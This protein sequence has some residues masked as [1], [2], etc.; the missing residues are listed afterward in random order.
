M[1]F[2]QPFIPLYFED[3]DGELWTALQQIEPERRSEFIKSV[4]RQTLLEQPQLDQ[5]FVKKV[6]GEMLKESTGEISKEST[7][8]IPKEGIGDIQKDTVEEIEKESFD[9]SIFDDV[10]TQIEP[11]H[12]PDSR[13]HLERDSESEAFSLEALFIGAAETDIQLRGSGPSDQPQVMTAA[14]PWDYL[15]HSVI[16]EEDDETVIAAIQQ[17]AQ[18]EAPSLMD[19]LSIE[20]EEPLKIDEFQEEEKTQEEEKPQTFG[21]DALFV[22][23]PVPTSGFEYVMKHIIGTEDD[24]EI[25]KIFKPFAE[26]KEI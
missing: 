17:A 2:S 6:L 22:E 21:L 25:L 4:L 23:S 11:E 1:I 10:V 16:G 14:T 9:K 5:P 20:M 18:A 24:E 13:A 8:D 15:L 7:E 19:P 26:K 3:D 12:P